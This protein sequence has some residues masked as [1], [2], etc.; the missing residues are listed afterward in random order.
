MDV[1]QD[2]DPRFLRR[3]LKAQRFRSFAVCQHRGEDRRRQLEQSGVRLQRRVLEFEGEVPIATAVAAAI[4]GK[5]VR[6]QAVAC[7]RV[8]RTIS[9]WAVKRNVV[10]TKCRFGT[11]NAPLPLPGPF[12]IYMN[13]QTI[14]ENVDCRIFVLP[15]TRCGGLIHRSSESSGVQSSGG[16]TR[17]R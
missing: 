5:V 4:E 14:G 17:N 9:V 16:D 1:I 3:F 15:C 13:R 10:P 12:I 6:R 8:S 11:V 7:H 2:D